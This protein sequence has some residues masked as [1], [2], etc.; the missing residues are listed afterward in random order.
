MEIGMFCGCTQHVS[1]SVYIPINPRAG[2]RQLEV[3]IT[4]RNGNGNGVNGIR[5]NWNIA[6]NQLDCPFGQTRSLMPTAKAASDSG[7]MDL[8]RS[9]RT[10]VS[11][12]LAPDG[13]LQ[14]FVQPTGQFDSFNFNNGVGEYRR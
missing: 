2:E 4:T 10:I 1:L 6:V 13:C 3:T 9:P 11:D 8:I 12:W 14:Y 7:L 5:P